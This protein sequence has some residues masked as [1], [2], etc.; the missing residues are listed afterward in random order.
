MVR[1][2]VRAGKHA[3]S[4]NGSGPGGENISAY[5]KTFFNKRPELLRLRSNDA[6]I[7]QWKADHGGTDEFPRSVMNGL[8][9]VKS[10]MR[11][12]A[13]IR[14]RRGRPRKHALAAAPA[15]ARV[16]KPPQKLLDALEEQID[17]CLSLIGGQDGLGRVVHVL[18]QARRLTI[19][20]MSE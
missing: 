12:Q 8:T 5:W 3:A 6:A 18:K 11:K 14:R 19:H 15:V 2:K 7:A 16:K 17:K 13:G 9:N 20:Q 4:M 1:K 10:S